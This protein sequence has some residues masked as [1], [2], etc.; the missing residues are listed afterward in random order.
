M[1]RNRVIYQSQA[2]QINGNTVAG[3]Q[4]VSYGLDLAREEINQFG[5]LGALDR[6]ILEAPTSNMEVTYYAS[7]LTLAQLGQAGGLL[8]GAVTGH[9]FP[10]RV[11][12]KDED[13]DYATGGTEVVITS[14]YLTSFS[15]EASVGAIPTQTLTFEGLDLTYGTSSA[16]AAPV[17]TRTFPLQ[18]DVSITLGGASDF[19]FFTTHAQSATFSFELGVEPLNQLGGA[20][21]YARVPSYPAS[22]T[23]A[24]EGLAVSGKLGAQI[25]DIN[26]VQQRASTGTSVGFDEYAVSVSIGGH[27][28][29]LVNASVDSVS[30]DSSVGDNATCNI[31]FA[32][33]IGGSA[34]RSTMR[35]VSA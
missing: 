8:S 13:Q 20:M 16:V 14:G 6:V 32:S 15:T 35:V 23:L 11:A 34:S 31:S 28:Y 29:E 33:S 12:L 5:Q 22:A 17:T 19:D 4:S 9:T 1:A 27:K 3:V 10:L 24:I 7:G 18:Q 30:F 21:A 26:A 2:V 25:A